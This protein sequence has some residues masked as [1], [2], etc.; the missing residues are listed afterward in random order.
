MWYLVRHNAG[1]N[2]TTN[3]CWCLKLLV[4]KIPSSLKRKSGVS[5]FGQYAD[6]RLVVRPDD[7]WLTFKACSGC[8][9]SVRNCE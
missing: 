7:D 5:F 1:W 3:T 8:I 4:L 6:E 9:Y 2:R